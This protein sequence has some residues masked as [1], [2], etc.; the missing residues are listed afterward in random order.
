MKQLIPV[1]AYSVEDTYLKEMS[2][3]LKKCWVFVGFTDDCD[4]HNDFITAK[5][6]TESIVIQ[7]FNGKLKAF[8]NIICTHR[9]SRIQCEKKGNRP[10]L[11]PYHGWNFGKDGKPI[12]VPQKPHF[13]DL[14][15][16][17]LEDLKLKEWQI[18]TCGKFMWLSSS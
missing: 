14:S 2:I 5:F 7:N 4:V 9:F 11:C 6:G 12:G 8:T 1:E 17:V 3:L 13:G 10:L 16:E 18:D 15:D